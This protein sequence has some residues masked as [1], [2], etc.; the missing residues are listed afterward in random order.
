MIG[1]YIHVK[2]AFFRTSLEEKK[3]TKRRSI[4]ARARSHIVYIAMSHI[5][6][7][8]GGVLHLL[9]KAPD[10]FQPHQMPFH[11]APLSTPPCQICHTHPT[12][13][14][15]LM[16]S[17]PHTHPYHPLQ[18][19]PNCLV[20]C[21][22]LKS[23]VRVM[24]KPYSHLQGRVRK[25]ARC[26][27]V[28]IMRAVLVLLAF[29]IAAPIPHFELI[30]ALVGGLATTI[31]AF[32]LPPAFHLLLFWKLKSKPIAMLNVVLLLFGVVAS[33][34]TTATT[35]IQIVASGPEKPIFCFADI[36]NAT[37]LANSTNSSGYYL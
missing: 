27:M 2:F 23:V 25:V 35:I 11:I 9:D 1:V 22:G 32:I 19:T 6:V 34:I 5:H 13:N 26:V 37:V 14:L 7:C 3:E 20:R 31:A 29:A 12:S 8:G 18:E 17:L 36:T 15:T 30:V 21:R 10:L 24:L 28:C 4:L 33:T 16:P